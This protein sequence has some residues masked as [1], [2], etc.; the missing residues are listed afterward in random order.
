MFTPYHTPYSLLR[1]LYGGST[2]F[3]AA[4]HHKRIV[5]GEC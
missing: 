5:R 3:N 2:Y 1:I 4:L